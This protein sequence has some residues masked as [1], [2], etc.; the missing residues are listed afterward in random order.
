MAGEKIRISNRFGGLIVLT[1]Q[2]FIKYMNVI[3]DYQKQ[4]ERF[5][6]TLTQVCDNSG[7]VFSLGDKLLDNYINLLSILMNDEGVQT[8]SWWLYDAPQNDKIIIETDTDTGRRKTYNVET[9]EDLYDY[10]CRCQP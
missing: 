9:V 8:I 3:F 6:N 10:L 1:K 4:N 2:E 7:V 5:S